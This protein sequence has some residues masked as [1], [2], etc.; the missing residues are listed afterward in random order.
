MKSIQESGQRCWVSRGSAQSG[1][2]TAMMSTGIDPRLSV[3]CIS[4]AGQHLRAAAAGGSD[5]SAQ[6][7]LKFQPSGNPSNGSYVQ[8]HIKKKKRW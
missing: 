4:K 6:P 8:S 5:L 1:L 2:K 7:G 3:L